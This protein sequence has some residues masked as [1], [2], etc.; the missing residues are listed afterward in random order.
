MSGGD[1]FGGT[2]AGGVR[3]GRGAG[4]E[5]GAVRQR[6]VGSAGQRLPPGATAGLAGQPSDRRLSGA[7]QPLGG[8][9][10]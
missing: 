7:F 9:L 6:L 3:G 2:C 10:E 4:G 1:R 8:R 5:F